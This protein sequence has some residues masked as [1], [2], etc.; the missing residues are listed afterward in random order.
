M[1]EQF[2]KRLNY[3][4]GLLAI[5]TVF[6]LTA[7]MASLEVK[8][9]D[10]WL[11]LKMGKVISQTLDVPEHDILSCTIA[12]KP[13]NNHEWL[14]QVIIYQIWNVWGFDGLIN[15]QIWVV[16]LSFLILIFLSY[17]KERQLLSAFFLL[18]VL[19]VYQ[20]RFT[21]RPDIFSL[22]FF[23]SYV[24]VLAW[25]IDRRWSLWLLVLIQ[26]LWTNMHG[27]F[28][29][30]PLLVLTAILAEFI[31]RR[32]PLPWEWNQTGRLKD[33]EYRRLKIFFP[34]LILACC[35]NPQTFIGAW[36]PLGVFLGLGH[37]DTKIFFEN[38]TE[39]QKPI[40]WSTIW[41]KQYGAYKL[42]ILLSAVALIL[43]RRRI[44]ISTVF[45]WIIFLLFSLV[46]VRNMVFFAMAAYLV[47]MAN[48]MTVNWKDV[49]PFRFSH[50]R[51]KYMTG[52]LCKGFL[53][54][55]MI[56]SGTKIAT[57]GYFD[58][59]TYERKSEFWGVSQRSFPYRA[60]DFLV[61]NR[62][63]GNFFND[64]NSG[65]YLI[66][67]A[68][69]DIKVY[70]DGRTEQYGGEF[71][72]RYQ[73]IWRDGNKDVFLKDAAKYR[74]TGVFLN[75]NNQFVPPKLLK[76]IYSL[77]EWKI[78]YFDYDAVIFLK[79]IPE[80]K[81]WID[82]FAVD[83]KKWQAKPMN[84]Q[85]LGTKRI[86]PIPITRRAY[87]LKTLGFYDAVYKEAQE[88]LKVSPDDVEAHKM[89]GEV[90][91]QR[92]QWRRAFEYYRIATILRPYD[93]ENRINLAKAYERLGDHKGAV[94][95]FERVTEIEPKNAR[96][97]FGI[98]KQFALLNQEKRALSYME[99]GRKLDPEDKVAVK[100][101]RDII[102][103]NKKPK[104]D[105]ASPQ[106]K[107]PERVNV[108]KSGRK[109]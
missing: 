22:L 58:F 32:V 77:P 30:G 69:P 8:D 64:F 25:F 41:V 10:L 24:W 4:F 26:V 70:I 20:T 13:W 73:K 49:V 62:I 85:R 11:H 71:F 48:I 45:I 100:K 29:F 74:L 83:L 63:K 67:R 42:M 51:F 34:F 18:L 12:G 44:D 3:I 98:A 31:K 53:I 6:G 89:L 37:A 5:G 105:M 91:E 35:I 101:I 21:I 102:D 7:F 39:L 68:Y 19:L 33:E 40:T 76:M 108:N 97:Y 57:N 79:D 81:A 92:K 36:Y 90:Y 54:F 75:N 104:T 27:F 60:V 2:W 1:S 43:N 17:S 47:F 99:E 103:K 28:F 52:L 109:E 86:D 94:A 46:A 56:D 9:L 84:L 87:L 88:A 14:F 80:N 15:M 65:A 50:D 61:K 82:R 72:R 16:L 23:V 38:I 106:V 78:V 66:G 55:W 59:D 96:A 107:V 95:Q 93:T